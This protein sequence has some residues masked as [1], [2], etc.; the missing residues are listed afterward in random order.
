[1]MGEFENICKDIKS[2][3]IQG[4]TNV[5]KAA[6][7]AYSLKPSVSSKRKLISLRPTEPALFNALKFLEKMPKKDVL[8][9]F[10]ISQENINKYVFKLIKGKGAVFTH[11][12]SSAVSKALIYSEKMGKRFEVFN[13]ETRPLY[14]GRKTAREL[15]KNNIPVTTYVDS[16]MHEAIKRCSIILLGA[17]A[18]LSSG[19]INKIGSAIAAEIAHVHNVPFYIV[20]DSWKFYPKNVKI[21][22]RDFKEVWENAPKSVKVK[23]PAFEL[24][25]KKYIRGVVSEYGTL[26]YSDFIR[27]A[28]KII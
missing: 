26:S 15:S 11:C 27:K 5:A 2:L 7:K 10:K 4:A 16:G 23:N 20:S 14:Q 12:H 1:M 28:S 24:I 8:D 18:L 13:T 22:E 3:K 6:I 21:E 19:A 25:P 9:H 17:D